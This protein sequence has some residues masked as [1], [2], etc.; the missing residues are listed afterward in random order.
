[1]FAWRHFLIYPFQGNMLKSKTV[2]TIKLPSTDD[3]ADVLAFDQSYKDI[4]ENN[5]LSAFALIIVFSNIS[6]L[7]YIFPASKFHFI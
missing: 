6:V 7:K 1:M 5:I 2:C 4:L 3:E